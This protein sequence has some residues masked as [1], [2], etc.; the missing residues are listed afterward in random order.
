MNRTVVE[1]FE[2]YSLSHITQFINLYLTQ[3]N[4]GRMIIGKDDLILIKPNLVTPAHPESCITTHPILIEAIVVN[5]IKRGY[6]NI[7][8]G[9]SGI[10]METNK[11]SVCGIYH[12]CEKYGCKPLDFDSDKMSYIE[13][14]ENKLLKKL[15]VPECVTRAKVIIN[16]PKAKTH[17]GYFY[18]GAVKN[19]YGLIYGNCKREIHKI[20]QNKDVFEDIIA[21]IWKTFSPKI[22]IMDSIDT[23]D[24]RGP[25]SGNRKH[26][27]MVLAGDSALALDIAFLKKMGTSE[28]EIGYIRKCIGITNDLVSCVN[29]P[30]DRSTFSWDWPSNFISQYPVIINE[31]CRK[32]SACE[33]ICPQN[34]ISFDGLRFYFNYDRCIKCYCCLEA[35]RTGAIIR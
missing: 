22:N 26:L 10:E 16:V 2:H 33:R 17:Q 32:C 15:P 25:I 28:T 8:I 11:F 13:S 24:G 20:A 31:K 27:G 18:T 35:C 1:Y 19:L 34:A 6:R 4:F 21:D 3:T 30:R 29:D 9:D 14:A 12:I 23:M 5:L 7:G